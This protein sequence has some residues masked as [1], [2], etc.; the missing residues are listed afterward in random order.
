MRL[1]RLAGRNVKAAWEDYRRVL[2]RIQERK[3]EAR[4]LRERGVIQHADPV[5]GGS[6]RAFRRAVSICSW[7]VDR[8]LYC[9][10]GFLLVVRLLGCW[11]L[12]LL[13]CWKQATQPVNC[14]TDNRHNQPTDATNKPIQTFKEKKQPTKQT[15]SQPIPE[16][17]PNQP[18]NT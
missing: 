2:E 8:I 5:G 15:S 1:R 11:L 13:G 16:N 18:T 4:S 6:L 14:P 17:Q 10:V 7:V 9:C 12:S 3:Q